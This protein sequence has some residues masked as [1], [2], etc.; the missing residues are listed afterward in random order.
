M[1]KSKRDHRRNRYKERN[2]L[3]ALDLIAAAAIKKSMLWS[4]STYG[5]SRCPGCGLTCRTHHLADLSGNI[6]GSGKDAIFIE[7][8]EGACAFIKCKGEKEWQ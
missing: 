4:M 8:F 6:G 1:P 3:R 2:R 5:G 7:A